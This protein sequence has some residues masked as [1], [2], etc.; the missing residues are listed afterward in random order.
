MMTDLKGQIKYSTHCFSGFGRW[1]AMLPEEPEWIF[2]TNEKG[3]GLFIQ[4][5]DS[6]AVRQIEGLGQFMPKN[7]DHFKR[8]IRMIRTEKLANAES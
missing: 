1:Q 5:R 7:F 2:C 3:E 4:W 8:M 6:G